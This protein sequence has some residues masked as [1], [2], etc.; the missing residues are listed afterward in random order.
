MFKIIKK[1]TVCMATTSQADQENRK[2]QIAHKYRRRHARYGSR[3][4]TNPQTQPQGRQNAAKKHVKTN[5]CLA[6]PL[7]PNHDASSH[8]VPRDIVKNAEK[9]RPGNAHLKPQYVFTHFTHACPGERS[10]SKQVE[11]QEPQ[12]KRKIS[13]N[14]CYTLI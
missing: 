14:F 5:P 7:K 2:K 13:R 12:N 6:L 1:H 10:Q 4:D 11:P 8:P 3:R 9:R